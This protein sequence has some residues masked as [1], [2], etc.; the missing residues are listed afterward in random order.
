MVILKDSM[1]QQRALSLLKEMLL[2][3]DLAKQA[4]T[5]SDKIAADSIARRSDCLF[6]HMSKF[7]PCLIQ[8]GVVFATIGQHHKFQRLVSED[9]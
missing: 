9:S 4:G 7:A 5:P 6:S 3:L 1:M 8:C 2:A